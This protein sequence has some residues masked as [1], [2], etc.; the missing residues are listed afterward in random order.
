MYA[1][2]IICFVFQFG[3]II[4]IN[5]N[6]DVYNWQSICTIVTSIVYLL[7]LLPFFAKVFFNIQEEQMAEVRLSYG[8]KD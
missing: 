3:S 6:A 4:A 7:I 2:V 8:V 1:L 5:Y